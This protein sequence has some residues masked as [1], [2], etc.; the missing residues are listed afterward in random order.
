M[1]ASQGTFSFSSWTTKARLAVGRHA[2][3]MDLPAN[4][5]SACTISP[6][7]TGRCSAFMAWLTRSW[8]MRGSLAASWTVNP[9][10]D[11]P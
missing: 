5:D 10:M 8:A 11:S 7:D 6:S 3:R 1:A 9:P 2:A 4:W